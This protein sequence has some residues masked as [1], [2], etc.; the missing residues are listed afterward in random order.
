MI[1][2]NLHTWLSMNKLNDSFGIMRKY[3]IPNSTFHKMV[4]DY[5]NL[6]ESKSTSKL[7]FESSITLTHK[8]QNFINQIVKP[9]TYP[10]SLHSIWSKINNEF[11][12]EV[13]KPIIKR[14]LKDVI[15]YTYKK[16]SSTTKRGGSNIIQVAKSIYSWKLLDNIIEDH[17][18][19]N[20]DES[21]F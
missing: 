8:M 9:P 19:I 5:R 1:G 20:V 6:K 17:Y 15:N 3:N 16:R 2:K 10:L 18:L 12:V 14:Y 21:S 7:K 13:K 4:K 11:G